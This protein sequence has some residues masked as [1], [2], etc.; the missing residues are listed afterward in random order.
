[1]RLRIGIFLL[2]AV[3]C[4]IT[5]CGGEPTEV[6]L[7]QLSR[8]Q[9]DYDGRRVSAQGV[10]RTHALPR[11]YWIEDDAFNRV[12]LEPADG[13]LELVG[14]RIQ[15]QGKFRYTPDR[16]RRIVVEQLVRLP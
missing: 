5:G 6:T 9:V 16:G 12:E 7:V 14:A 4:A 10:L 15:V 3:I 13:L 11:H 8:Q 1:M 2:A